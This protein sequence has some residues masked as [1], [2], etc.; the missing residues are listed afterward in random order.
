M[1]H[2]AAPGRR[3]WDAVMLSL[4]LIAVVVI[5]LLSAFDLDNS[6]WIAVLVVMDIS[7]VVDI[8]VQARTACAI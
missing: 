2:P 8:V 1:F 7:F 6:D 3:A 5:P 4:M